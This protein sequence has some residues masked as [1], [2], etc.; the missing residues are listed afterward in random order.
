VSDVAQLAAWLAILGGGL[1]CCVLLHRVGVATTYVR[2]LLHV[3]AGVWVVGW[4][5][6]NDRR[7]PIAI[8]VAAAVGIWLVPRVRSLGGFRSAVSNADER[9]L[10]LSLYTVS[11]AA[12]TVLGLTA[13]RAEAGAALWALTLGDGLGGAV[14]RRFGRHFFSV[15]G[16]KKKSWEGTLAVGVFAAAGAWLAALWLGGVPRPIAAGLT[17]AAA[18]ALA[19]RST[20]NLTV[21]AAVYLVLRGLS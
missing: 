7:W 9:W 12:F 3:G 10:G 8:T 18:E 20:D 21:P 17:A 19:P 5:F 4:P 15:P 6:W 14:G 1:A 11:F 16:G 2:D 13:H